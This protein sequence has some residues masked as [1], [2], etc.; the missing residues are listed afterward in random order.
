[1]VFIVSQEAATL[2]APVRP[3]CGHLRWSNPSGWSLIECQDAVDGDLP[4]RRSFY[5]HLSTAACLARAGLLGLWLHL[6]VSGF[7]PVRARGGHE[8]RFWMRTTGT[9]LLAVQRRSV[10]GLRASVRDSRSAHGLLYLAAVW[11]E[12]RKKEHCQDHVDVGSLR[13]RLWRGKSLSY[14]PARM[15]YRLRVYE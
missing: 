2:S 9:A 13:S 14:L 7:R 8:M 5:G 6:N 1:M 12:K 3:E 4:L 15:A 10:A 11:D